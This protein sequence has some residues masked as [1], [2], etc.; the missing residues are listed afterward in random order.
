VCKVSVSVSVA[1]SCSLLSNG[2]LSSSASGDEMNA[3]V[4]VLAAVRIEPCRLALDDI[5]LQG[6]QFSPKLLYQVAMED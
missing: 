2:R 3:L 6:E 4:S 5:V 1:G